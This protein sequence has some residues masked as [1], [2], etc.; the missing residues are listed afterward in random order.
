MTNRVKW[1]GNP[2]ALNNAVE[3]YSVDEVAEKYGVKRDTVFVTCKRL[4]IVIPKK[5]D[6]TEKL[7]K[8]V[9]KR[10]PKMTARQL[11]DATGV[12]IKTIIGRASRGQIVVSR[13]REHGNPIDLERAK[14]MCKTMSIRQMHQEF[15]VGFARM[16]RFLKEHGLQSNTQWHAQAVKAGKIQHWTQRNGVIK[17]RVESTKKKETTSIAKAENIIWPDSVKIQVIKPG[18]CDD[19][20]NVMTREP[21]TKHKEISWRY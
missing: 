2:K 19:W 12:S 1:Y 13:E 18:K 8:S 20:R 5:A 10:N 14:E 4:G 9:L 17:K 16:S 15:K 7:L 11:S 21:L 3:K 6:E